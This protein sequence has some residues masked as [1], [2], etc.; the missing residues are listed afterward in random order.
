MAY[1]LPLRFI[2]V[3]NRTSKGSVDVGICATRIVAMMSTDNYYARKTIKKERDAGT[4]IN[5]AGREKVK[6]AIWLDNGSV[7]ASPL[8][9][10]VIMNAINKSNDI[11][12]GKFRHVQAR[13]Y[14]F[15]EGEADQEFA[16]ETVDLS[17]DELDEEEDFE[18]EDLEE[19][20]EPVA[21]DA[22]DDEEEDS[23]S[24]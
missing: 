11:A 3:A 9:V 14:E 22:E 15:E 5:A 6:C 18:D 7:V 16:T 10:R 20:E 8:S 12:E 17:S 4:L 2:K 19:D 21:E 24:E 1:M 13:V 23:A